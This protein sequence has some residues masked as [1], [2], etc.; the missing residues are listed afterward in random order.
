MKKYKKILSL[1]FVVSLI[2]NMNMVFVNATVTDTQ[3]KIKSVGDEVA[4]Q[5]DDAIISFQVEN[6]SPTQSVTIKSYKLTTSESVNIKGNSANANIKLEKSVLGKSDNVHFLSFPVKILKSA[7]DGNKRFWLELTLDRAGT[8]KVQSQ[9]LS[10]QIVENSS[11]P[12]GDRRDLT[13]FKIETKINPENGFTIGHDNTFEVTSINYGNTVL[14]DGKIEISLPEGISVYNGSN[15]K[16]VGYISSG[17]KKKATFRIMVD[18][19][20]KSKSYPI[21]AKIVGKVGN[22]ESVSIDKTF[23]ISV[24]GKEDKDVEIDNIKIKNTNA[25]EQVRADRSFDI[26]FDVENQ[27]NIDVKNAKINIELPEGIV[28]KSRTLFVKNLTKKSSQHFNV[29]L[30]AKEGIEEKTHMIKVTV[31]TGEEENNILTQYLTVNVL[32][33]ENAS[34]KKPQLMVHDYDYGGSPVESGKEFTFGLTIKNTSNKKLSNIKVQLESDG[35]AFVPAKGSNSFYIEEIKGK[36][37]YKENM[38]LV[39]VASVSSTTKTS[40]VTVNMSYE[41]VSG[42]TYEATDTISIP[43]VQKTRL[44]IDEL[45][46]P[47][48]V[49]VG[50]PNSCE[51]QFYNMGKTTLENLRVNCKGNFDVSETNS[52]Y[53]GNMESG[54]SDSYSFNFIPRELGEMTGTITFTY[55]NANGDESIKEVPFTFEVMEMMEE[56]M[57][58]WMMDEPME[59]EKKGMDKKYIYGGIVGVIILL[60]AGTVI[61]KKIKARKMDK[62]LNIE[63][64]DENLENK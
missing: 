9:A 36:E 64:D 38:Q 59:E 33:N 16:T 14:K 50:M 39:S 20:V 5:G 56:P 31:D 26:S 46:P 11:K 49:Y 42:N 29:K 61:M 57:D 24:K 55:E 18:E 15:S 6:T 53:A 35:G 2:L 44:V 17:S 51:L 52:Y 22:D 23:Y 13:A 25:P 41:D 19:D 4:I 58:D 32:A 30:F 62:E 48:E 10:F 60:I 63:L 12:G 1:I 40:A 3:V 7:D 45:I 54:K 21:E 27:G 43:V 34:A 37:Q 47:M 8:P 28:N